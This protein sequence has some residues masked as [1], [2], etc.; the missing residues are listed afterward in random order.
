MNDQ[1]RR[2]LD[3]VR[4]TGDRMVVTDPNGNDP[5]VVMD[6]DSY[7]ELLG[8][9][10][11][12]EWDIP[13]GFD[14]EEELDFEEEVSRPERADNPQTIWDTM[15]SAGESGETWDLSEL[16]PQ[17]LADLEAKFH[18]YASKVKEVGDSPAPVESSGTVEAPAEV[19]KEA[20]DDF[21][22]EQ[23]YLEPIE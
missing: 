16:N 4:A 6:L 3:L 14:E 23:F 11:A 10:L 21:G 17:E 22:E 8:L 5:I 13:E 9:E 20:E 7:E 2:I 12:E 15:K 19:P 1:F 18:D